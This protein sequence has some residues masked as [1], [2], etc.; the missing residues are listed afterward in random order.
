MNH[1]PNESNWA[2][3][4]RCIDW[5]KRAVKACTEQGK[6]AS[7]NKLVAVM[8]VDFGISDRKAKEYIQTLIIAGKF[9]Q[10]GDELSWVFEEKQSE[11]LDFGA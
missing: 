7:K 4:E 8:G 10:K 1:P 5:L 3:R 11:V 2:K 9:E 6:T